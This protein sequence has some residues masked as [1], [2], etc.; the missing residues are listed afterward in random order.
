M[1]YRKELLAFRD[2]VLTNKLSAGQIALWYALFAMKDISGRDEWFTAPYPMLIQ[3]SGLSRQGIIKARNVLQQKGLIEFKS[4]K[5]RATM[6]KITV[7]SGDMQ[8]S[9]QNSI[10]DSIQVGIQEQRE[11]TEKEKCAKE[12]EKEE[13]LYN[14]INNMRAC[15]ENSLSSEGLVDVCETP[16]AGQMTAEECYEQNIGIITPANLEAIDGLRNFGMPD[17]VICEAIKDA[18]LNNKRSWRYVERI[19]IDKL[20]RNIKTL[21][22]YRRDRDEWQ[23]KKDERARGNPVQ[24]STEAPCTQTLAEM[25]I[26]IP[27][28]VK[29]G[30]RR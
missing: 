25:Y 9:I 23:Q 20:K 21:E 7:F 3:M 17:D 13:K 28:W 29:K 11:E 2:F 24:A 18:A 27:D 19:L 12:K 14:N 8:N 15:E 1:E 22:A 4:D 10:Q 30:G 16:G 5:T 26:D 6:Y